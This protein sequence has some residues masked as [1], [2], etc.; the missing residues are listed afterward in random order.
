MH[1]GART[2]PEATGE[3][4]CAATTLLA[5]AAYNHDEGSGTSGPDVYC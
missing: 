2:E 3:P 5:P 4:P 1:M